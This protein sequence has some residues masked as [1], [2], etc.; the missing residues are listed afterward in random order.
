MQEGEFKS[1]ELFAFKQKA[2]DEFKQIKENL[3]ARHSP[4]QVDDVV[5]TPTSIG[6]AEDWNPTQ[7]K[8]RVTKVFL[9]AQHWWGGIGEALSFEYE[10]V[11]L[12]KTGEPMKNRKPIRFSSADKD[13]KRVKMPS[14]MK[15]E[16]DFVRIGK[17]QF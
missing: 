6:V 13:S 14:Y 9:F 11:L 15:H 16:L 17:Y 10:G 8:V 3:I 5:L 1:S 12:S 7:Q 4:I 2:I